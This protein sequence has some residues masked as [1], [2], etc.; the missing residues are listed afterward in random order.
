MREEA[1]DLESA[2]FFAVR[3]VN[4]GA[5]D[6]DHLRR[7]MGEHWAFGLDP[8]GKR[9]KPWDSRSMPPGLYQSGGSA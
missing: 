7:A 3:A 6:K 9:S 8:D 2:E 4:A 5:G 1:G